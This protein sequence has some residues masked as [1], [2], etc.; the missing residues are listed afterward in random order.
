M[1]NHNQIYESNPKVAK[2]RLNMQQ[3]DASS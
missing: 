2:S 1:D 3:Q